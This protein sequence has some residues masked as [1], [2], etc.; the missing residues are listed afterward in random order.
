MTQILLK[1]SIKSNNDYIFSIK[2]PIF[3]QYY[4]MLC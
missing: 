3:V 1:Y 4:I 2:M